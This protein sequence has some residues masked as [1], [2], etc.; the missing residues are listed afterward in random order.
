MRPEVGDQVRIQVQRC[1]VFGEQAE[2]D[3]QERSSG[4]GKR[5]EL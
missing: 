1:H 2:R 5:K 3:A 4:C